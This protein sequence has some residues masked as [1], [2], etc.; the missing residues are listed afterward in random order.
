MIPK[1]TSK[2]PRA[3]DDRVGVGDAPPRPPP[4]PPPMP[5][6]LTKAQPWS[7]RERGTNPG[8][9]REVAAVW[10]QAQPLWARVQ[11]KSR[12]GISGSL[13]RAHFQSLPRAQGDVGGHTG[14]A[15]TPPT[16]PCPATITDGRGSGEAPGRTRQIFQ[17][18]LGPP[19]WPKLPQTRSFTCTP[20]TASSAPRLCAGPREGGDEAVTDTVLDVSK[21]RTVSPGCNPRGASRQVCGVLG[22]SRAQLLIPQEE[23]RRSSH[24]KCPSGG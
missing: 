17:V 5:P 10:G 14:P 8:R 23:G 2:R 4:A 21:R 7:Q 12:H 22:P 18:M 16:H 19:P 9:T 3:S 15:F 1:G 20:L 11:A 6:E 24:R 13:P